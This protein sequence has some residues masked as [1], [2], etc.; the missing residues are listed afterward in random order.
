MAMLPRG[1]PPIDAQVSWDE[2]DSLILVGIV[3]D[4]K[5]L[6]PAKRK[7][8]AARIRARS[9]AVDCWMRNGVEPSHRDIAAAAQVSDRWLSNQFPRKNELYAFPPAE[10]ARSCAF[11]SG[12]STSRAWDDIAELVRPAFSLLQTNQTVKKLMADLVRLHRIHPELGDADA[13]FALAMREELKDRRSSRTLS[14]AELF[15]CGV[16]LAFQDWVDAGEPNLA[17][18]AD[19]VAEFVNGPVRCAYDALLELPVPD[20]IR[21][22]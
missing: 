13:T 9:Y 21:N 12:A 3:A 15:A 6:T 1:L 7:T 20:P 11:L 18:V 17:F 5:S 10:M 2:I 19:R 4:G 16:R 8:A 22:F 14:I